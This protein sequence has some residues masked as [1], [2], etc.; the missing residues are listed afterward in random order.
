MNR[1]K[2]S[3]EKAVVSKE[4]EI[5]TLKDQIDKEKHLSFT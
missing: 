5:L 3:K 4:K 1:D 2:Q